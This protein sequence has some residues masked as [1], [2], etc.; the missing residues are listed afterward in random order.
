MEKMT[1]QTIK[2]EANSI[3][4]AREM[5]KSQ[6]PKGLYVLSEKVLSDGKQQII[7]S[8]AETTDAAF[9]KA[10]Y[11]IPKDAIIIGKKVLRSSDLRCIKVEAFDE[12]SAKEKIKRQIKRTEKVKDLKLTVRGSKGL[13]GV[14][15]KPNQYE[16]EILQHAV[17]RI[18]YKTKVVISATLGTDVNRLIRALKSGD[19]FIRNTGMVALAE[20]GAQAVEPLLKA[21]QN[22][23]ERKSEGSKRWMEWDEDLRRNVVEIFSQAGEPV[24]EP[25]IAALNDTARSVRSLAAEALGRICDPSAVKPLIAS[26]SDVSIRKTAIE[27]LMQIGTPAIEP[28]TTVLKSDSLNWQAAGEIVVFLVKHGVKVTDPCLQKTIQ[29]L[30]HWATI[31]DDDEYFNEGWKRISGKSYEQQRKEAQSILNKLGLS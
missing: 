5:I 25:L 6:L 7:E 13:L 31:E 1:D 3:E 22:S 2:V 14:R 27:S 21:Y 19:E 18:T 20:I 9:E 24:V 8:I 23:G 11:E 4:E 30:K 17:V 29:K 28:L 12:Q 15:K 26:L 16:I 10:R